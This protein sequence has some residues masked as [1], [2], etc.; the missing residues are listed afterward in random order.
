MVGRTVLGTPYAGVFG[1]LDWMVDNWPYVNGRC[2]LSGIALLK[3]DASDMLDVVHYMFEDDLRVSSAEE[4][5]AVSKIRETMYP[6][7]YGRPYKSLFTSSNTKYNMNTASSGPIPTV[8]TPPGSERKPYI[9]PTQFDPDSP[10]PFGEK[11]DS[12]LK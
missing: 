6:L 7:L 11:L 8:S 12:P 1:L 4:A 10:V 3:M 2:L 5:E 9:P